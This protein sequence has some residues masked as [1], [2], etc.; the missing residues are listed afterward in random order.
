MKSEVKERRET[1]LVQ[2][3]VPVLGGRRG[4]KIEL[5]FVLRETLNFNIPS[6]YSSEFS[7]SS[8]K[9]HCSARLV[10][11]HHKPASQFKNE[12]G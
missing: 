1:V 11:R 5:V 9:S 3:N 7:Q 6:I 4:P 8:L 10:H 2:H 12:S